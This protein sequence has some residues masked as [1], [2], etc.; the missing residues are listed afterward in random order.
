V[1][2]VK[3]DADLRQLMAASSSSTA[4]ST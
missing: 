3:R 4:D 1:A 2:D